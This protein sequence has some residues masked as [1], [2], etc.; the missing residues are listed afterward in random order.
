MPESNTMK[1]NRLKTAIIKEELALKKCSLTEDDLR[2]TIWIYK[3]RRGNLFTE[4]GKQIDLNRLNEA[5]AWLNT[6]G[7]GLQTGWNAVKAGGQWAAKNIPPVYQKGKE[8]V[9]KGAEEV[10]NLYQAGKKAG[11]AIGNELVDI[12]TAA[13]K[14][15]RG[16]YQDVRYGT[17]PD[18][19]P[20]Q[21]LAHIDDYKQKQAMQDLSRAEVD[22]TKADIANKTRQAK[23][24]AAATT[25]QSKA[26]VQKSAASAEIDKATA[27]DIEAKRPLDWK[28]AKKIAA[29][30]TAATAAAD[31]ALQ[32]DPDK[33]GFPNYSPGSG[34]GYLLPEETLGDKLRRWRRGEPDPA[35]EVTPP[36]PPAPAP[37]PA[38]TEPA[39]TEPPKEEPVPP[40]SD[41]YPDEYT[42]G[43]KPKPDSGQG[44]KPAPGNDK[45]IAMQKKLKA[46]GY[47]LGTF[48]PEGDGIDG[49]WGRKTQAAYDAYK[50]DQNLKRAATPDA[51]SR[52]RERIAAQSNLQQAP[53]A[54]DT[55]SYGPG[56]A[57]SNDPIN[58]VIDTKQSEK[59]IPE[60]ADTTLDDILWLAG[61][62]RK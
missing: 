35:P 9:G 5:P 4:S 44:G 15:L 2:N 30:T 50:A 41:V 56:Y 38:K 60:A 20:A 10:G 58:D 43:V 21:R 19:D 17:T 24:D 36:A 45:V 29:G 11:T 62:Q 31:T 16:A 48:G 39:K 40:V 1:S 55:T 6:I 22:A 27:R 49:K 57:K 32:Y 42:R 34:L 54:S 18:M 33:G 25:R 37:A 59:V 8:L 23:A 12:P 52:E 26:D 61:K 47:D 3:D 28:P 46:A 7:Q 14:K 13:A 53:Q 51:A